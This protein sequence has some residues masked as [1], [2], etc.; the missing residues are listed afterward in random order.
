MIACQADADRMF[1][2]LQYMLGRFHQM[3]EN[4]MDNMHTCALSHLRYPWPLDPKCK[5]CVRDLEKH[6][7]RN[8]LEMAYKLFGWDAMIESY[9]LA[10][11]LKIAQRDA[12]LMKGAYI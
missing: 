12:N 9:I 5:G 1:G 4:L 11:N 8:H 3:T 10:V 7:R 6:V 2:D